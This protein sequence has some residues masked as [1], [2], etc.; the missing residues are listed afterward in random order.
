MK[1]GFI[2]T[3]AMGLPMLRNLL[4][5]GFAVTAYDANPAALDV[6]VAAGAK[7]AASCADVARA[8][9]GIVTILPSASNVQAAYLGPSGILEAAAKGT[10]CIDMSTIDPGTARQVAARL[11]ERGVRYIDAPVSGGVAGATA[12]SLT[13]MIGGVASDVE[14]ARPALVA[15]GA[16]LVHVGAVGAGS[17]A[18]LCNNLIAGVAFVAV[19]EA[20]RIGEAWGV[21]PKILTDVISTSSGATWAMQKNHPVPGIDPKAAASRDYAPGFTTD[22]MGK[23]LGLAVN[24]AREGRVA[25]SVAAAAQ[26]VYRMAS[27]HGFGRKDC[28]SVYQFLK[29]GSKDS[30]V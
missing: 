11:A 12:G 23:D 22:L 13:I 6:A 8:S 1:L 30:P 7:R 21:D 17:V 25:A 2:G 16:N 19:S 3:G 10:L 24:A 20:F 9:E 26:Q 4:A 14:A 28:A 18:K 29:P 27:A 15:M 5:K